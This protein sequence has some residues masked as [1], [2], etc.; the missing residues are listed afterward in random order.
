M[1]SADVSGRCSDPV[2]GSLRG[3]GR[4]SPFTGHTIPGKGQ[5]N[6]SPTLYADWV[7]NPKGIDE[8]WRILPNK[9]GSLPK[10]PRNPTD[11]NVGLKATNDCPFKN[12]RNVPGVLKSPQHNSLSELPSL[13]SST[14]D[15]FSLSLFCHTLT[16]PPSADISASLSV[17]FHIK[18]KKSV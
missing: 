3:P 14:L 15:L 8:P 9:R 10:V 17:S 4:Y 1:L 6:S 12:S 11:W 5:Q 18:K 16:P 13:P 2:S 7:M